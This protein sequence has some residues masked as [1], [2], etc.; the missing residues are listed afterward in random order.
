L[1]AMLR[2]SFGGG[3]V[4]A[5]VGVTGSSMMVGVGVGTAVLRAASFSADM[6]AET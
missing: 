6:I 2:R 1:K 3:R 5:G 4:D